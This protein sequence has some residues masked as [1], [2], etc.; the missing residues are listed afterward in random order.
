MQIRCELGGAL[1][2]GII[3]SVYLGARFT[4]DAIR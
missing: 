1:Q 4:I 3:V 2:L